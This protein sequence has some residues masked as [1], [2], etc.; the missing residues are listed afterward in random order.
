MKM[1]DI[2][3]SGKR[4]QNVSLPSP[5][6]QISRAHVVPANPRTASQIAVRAVFAKVVTRWR[7][8]EEVERVAWIS[9]AKDVRTESRLGQN[10]PLTG[11]QL[12]TR[13]NQTLALFGQDQVDAPSA[14]PMFPDLA[15]QELVITNTGGEI[16]LKLRCVGSP[17]N[18]TIVRGSAPLS[19]GR[20]TCDKYRVLGMCPAPAE[21]WADITSL[22]TARYGV[23]PVD[24]KVFVRVNQYVGGWQDLPVTFWAIVP[25]AE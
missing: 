1:L 12:F 23:P 5:Y 17:G 13:I 24:T 20:G 10:G 9:A 16:A 15:P 14:R 19:Q 11:A 6:G 18:H 8:L 22:Y 25:G 3:Q 4:G 2:P 7:T 21:G